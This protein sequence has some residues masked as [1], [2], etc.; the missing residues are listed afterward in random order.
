MTGD[1]YCGKC[2]HCGEEFFDGDRVYEIDGLTLCQY[3]AENYLR[4]IYSRILNAND[5]EG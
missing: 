4:V 3:C 2:D 1:I 5:E